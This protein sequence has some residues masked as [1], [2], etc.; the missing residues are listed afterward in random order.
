MSDREA[1][2][3]LAGLITALAL[4]VVVYYAIKPTIPDIVNAK[5]VEAITRMREPLVREAA[6]LAWNGGLSQIVREAVTGA[7]P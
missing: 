1:G 6:S 2:Y 3:F 4:E 5:A 7:L